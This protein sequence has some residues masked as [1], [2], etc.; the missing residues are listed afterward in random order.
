[1]ISFSVGVNMGKGGS[2]YGAGRPGWKRKA[3]ASLA[4]DIRQLARKG[5]LTPGSWFSWSWTYTNTGENAGSAGVRVTD[6]PERVILSY[7]WTPYGGDPQS[8]ECALQIDRTVCNYGGSRPWFLCPA[9]WRR[10]AVVYFGRGRYACRH[11]NHVAYYSQSEDLMGRAWRKQHKLE[12]KLNDGWH[13]P[14]GMHWKT[15]ERLRDGIIECEWQKDCA[16]VVA[17]ARMGIEI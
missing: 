16:L 6:N 8:V 17:M 13:R 3:E 12:A 1:M 4:L 5:R 14:K 2:R 9:C 11:C 10:C 15:Y 7:Q